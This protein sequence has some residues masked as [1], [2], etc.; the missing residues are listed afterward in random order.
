MEKPKPKYIFF[1]WSSLN[2]FLFWKKWVYD[3][4]ALMWRKLNTFWKKLLPGYSIMQIVKVMKEQK[5]FRVKHWVVARIA[6]YSTEWFKRPFSMI[7]N[8]NSEIFILQSVPVFVTMTVTNLKFNWSF[9][10]LF[11]T[12][13]L[14]SQL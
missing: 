2:D 1:T 13:V 7:N 3:V 4:L 9:S 12:H 5:L 6:T 11:S 8:L 10:N 14:V